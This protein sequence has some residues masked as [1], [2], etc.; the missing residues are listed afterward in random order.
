MSKRVFLGATAGEVHDVGLNLE[1]CRQ[2]IHRSRHPSLDA[3]SATRPGAAV[4]DGGV[5]R[6]QFNSLAL[7]AGRFWRLSV[8]GF[9]TGM[10]DSILDHGLGAPRTV[11]IEPREPGGD[12]AVTG[13]RHLG[14]VQYQGLCGTDDSNGNSARICC[15][16]KFVN[17]D[18]ALIKSSRCLRAVP[19]KQSWI[20][21]RA[22]NLSITELAS[23]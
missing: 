1:L 12:P 3:A 17:V 8:S 14:M 15:G 19:E 10:T 9:L 7:L 23:Q 2:R 13:V 5:C 20:P 11:I 4:Q 16:P 21:L 22:F 18:A 6:P